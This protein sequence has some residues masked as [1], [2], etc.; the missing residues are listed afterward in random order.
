VSVTNSDTG[1]LRANFGGV[2]SDSFI[3]GSNTFY[4][5]ETSNVSVSFLRNT[6][7]VDTT[8]THVSAKEVGQGWTVANRDSTHY[9]EFPGVGARYVSD[10][11]FPQLWLRQDGIITPGKSYTVTCNVAYASGSGAVKAYVGGDESLSLAEGFNTVTLTATT[12]SN[13]AITRNASNVD[14]VI[15]NVTL[16]QVG[17]GN[18]ERWWRMNGLEPLLITLPNVA[19]NGTVNDCVPSGTPIIQLDTP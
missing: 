10:T 8:F 17:G 14:C 16:T 4:A 1:K 11:T 7:D 6:N 18:L 13:F 12:G 5:S 9:V 3:D 2:N 19:P 15:T